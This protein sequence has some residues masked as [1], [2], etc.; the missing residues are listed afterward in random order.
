MRNGL[1]DPS[2]LAAIVSELDEYRLAESEADTSRLTLFGNMGALL[3]GAGNTTAMVAL[4]SLWHSMTH[5]RPFFMCGYAITSQL[6]EVPE[7]WSETCAAHLGSQSR[8]RHLSRD[9]ARAAIPEERWSIRGVRGRGWTRHQTRPKNL[10]FHRLALVEPAVVNGMRDVVLHDKS[11]PFP[12]PRRRGRA[13]P[14]NSDA[15]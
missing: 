1:P 4:E 12:L 5:Q 14:R 13:T 2:C 6:N 8:E 15:P 3:L 11:A 7:L 10:F 9:A